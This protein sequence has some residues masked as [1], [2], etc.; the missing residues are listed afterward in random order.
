LLPYKKKYTRNLLKMIWL[1]N[2]SF[3]RE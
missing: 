1:L 2:K 3:M